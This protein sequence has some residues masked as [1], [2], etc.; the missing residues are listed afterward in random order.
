MVPTVNTEVD[1]WKLKAAGTWTSGLHETAEL[2]VSLARANCMV[3][4]LSLREIS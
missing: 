2:R 4:Y 1:R 3:L